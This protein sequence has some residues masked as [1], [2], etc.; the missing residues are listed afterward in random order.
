MA[1]EARLKFTFLAF[2]ENEPGDI[3]RAR[4]RGAKPLKRQKRAIDHY[5]NC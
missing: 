4:R 2:A 3:W 5:E 1:T